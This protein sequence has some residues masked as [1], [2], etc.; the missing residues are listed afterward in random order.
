MLH[1]KPGLVAAVLLLPLVLSLSALAGPLDRG[2][3]GP[4]VNPA[5]N[6]MLR[7]PGV[8]GMDPQSAFATLQQA[9]LNP[10]VHTI[11][12]TIKKYA[13]QEGTVVTQVPAAGGMAML[14][15]SVSLA[16][17]N[18]GG[19][20][21]DSPVVGTGQEASPA[22]QHGDVG[23]QPD[24]SSKPPDSSIPGMDDETGTGGADTA[25]VQPFSDSGWHGPTQATTSPAQTND[26]RV[27]TSPQ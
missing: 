21:N 1:I 12:R 13:G 17:Y 11:L 16:V 4:R 8:I 26:L 23:G 18:P 3:V 20:A 15:S 14:G 7:V 27:P 9:G 6:D 22:D 10:R 19:T 24:T 25:Q 5:T 2:D